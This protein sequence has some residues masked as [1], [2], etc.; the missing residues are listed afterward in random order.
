M[1]QP[2]ALRALDLL[3]HRPSSHRMTRRFRLVALQ[4]T[5]KEI[6]MSLAD[7]LEQRFGAGFGADAAD[8]TLDPTL[9]RMLSRRT[10]RRYADRPVSPD[11][12]D[13]IL[14]AALSA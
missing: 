2:R 6:R 7:L 8:Q 10:H 3:V 12:I 14:H 1:M 4:V 13:T 5:E 9:Q 11:L